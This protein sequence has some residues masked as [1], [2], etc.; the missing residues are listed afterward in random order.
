MR[1]CEMMLYICATRGFLYYVVVILFLFCFVL[2]VC[3]LALL[4]SFVLC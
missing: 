3:F 2:F 1:W 4:D